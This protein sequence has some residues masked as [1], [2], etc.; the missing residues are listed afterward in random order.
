MNFFNRFDNSDKSV[1]NVKPEVKPQQIQ[2]QVVR[3]V[4]QPQV[5]K[6]TTST[7]SLNTVKETKMTSYIDIQKQIAEL[8]AQADKV[9]KEE[10]SEVIASVKATVAEYKLSVSDIF[11]NVKV[12]AGKS[13]SAKV[14]KIVKY[15]DEEGNTWAG[16]TDDGKFRR[17]IQPLW[18]RNIIESRPDDW[19]VYI[20]KFRVSE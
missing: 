17:G 13:A 11:P 3:P 9:R 19:K 1:L 18:V 6:P 2:P 15:R 14:E 16:L 12:K 7:L 10:L 5:A 4:S 8:Q 20:E